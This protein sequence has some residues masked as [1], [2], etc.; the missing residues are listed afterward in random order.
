MAGVITSMAAHAQL[1]CAGL[2]IPSLKPV[3][4]D[5]IRI[6]HGGQ[7][8]VACHGMPIMAGKIQIHTLAK[9]VLAQKSGKHADH[10]GAFFIDCGGVKI[11]DLFI[12]F[13]ADRMCRRAPVFRKLC[14]AKQRHIIRALNTCIM[15]I[16]RKTL[17]AEHRQPFFQGQ[18]EPVTTGHPVACPIVKIFVRDNRFNAMQI[19]ICC[20]RGVSQNKFAVKNIQAFIFHRPHIEMAYRDDLEQIKIIFKTIFL[21][22]PPHRADQRV[23]RMRCQFCIAFFDID[24]QIDGAA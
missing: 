4:I 19:I 8:I 3:K 16:R 24:F 10:F 15:H 18:L 21:F 6:G 11:I 9:G 20:G 17:V 14:G 5:I 22:I 13:R 2:L 1:R 23:H 12:G 7:K